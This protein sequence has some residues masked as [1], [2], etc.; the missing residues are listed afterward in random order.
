MVGVFTG[1]YFSIPLIP[2]RVDPREIIV[3]GDHLA[4]VHSM[5]LGGSEKPSGGRITPLEH[6]EWHGCSTGGKLPIRP[7]LST[8]MADTSS[9]VDRGHPVDGLVTRIVDRSAP[10]LGRC[11][12]EETGRTDGIE[13][14]SAINLRNIV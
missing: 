11:G 7:V 6:R 12:D 4:T 2:A 14:N 5:A 1:L 8:H 10:G 9:R 3:L 13:P